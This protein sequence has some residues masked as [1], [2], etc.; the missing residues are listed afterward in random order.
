M[1]IR[2]IKEEVIYPGPHALE[3]MFDLQLVLVDHYTKIE[4]LPEYPVDINT[5]VGQDLIKDFSARI[6]EEFGEGFESY[7]LMLEM[8][9][10]GTDEKQMI[11]DLQN[12]NEEIADAIHFWLELLIF[13]G[14]GVD[15]M[16]HWVNGAKVGLLE[17]WLTRAEEVLREELFKK[18]YPGRWVIKDHQLKDE[19]LR[20]GR[21]IST[22]R[23]DVMRGLL[24]D[25]TYW[26]QVARNTLKN[27]PW[28]QTGVMTDKNQ[29]EKGIAEATFAM[30]KF[31]AFTG[32]TAISLHHIYYKKNKVNQFRIKSKY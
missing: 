2:N 30:F 31:F 29:Y 14:Y 23:K 17:Y 7:L 32:F 25:I 21:M 1:D 6:I 16:A 19:F 15:D 4:S 22:E 27:K 9:R 18:R 5:K 20:G 28:K 24:W 12:F 26:F 13:S 3:A 10:S 11:T 8:F